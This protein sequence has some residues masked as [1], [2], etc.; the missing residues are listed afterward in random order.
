MKRKLLPVL[1]ALL[2]GSMACQKEDPDPQYSGEIELSSERLSSGN[3]WV[4]YGFDFESGQI[5]T[6]SLTGSSLPDLSCNHIILNDELKSVYLE[7]SEDQ[8]A[9][10]KYGTYSTSEEAMISFNAYKEVTTNDFIP[11][12]QEIQENQI[13]TVQTRNNTFAKIWIRDIRILSGAQSLYAAVKIQYS[14]QPD[15]SRSFDCNCEE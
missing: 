8:E 15:G 9:F 10:S 1:T 5:S 14:Y 7:S 4:F 2:I 11:L 13:W 3:D 6:Y 12:A